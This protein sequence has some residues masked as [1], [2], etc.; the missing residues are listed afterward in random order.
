MHRLIQASA[1]NTHASVLRDAGYLR[2]G[3][4]ASSLSGF[5]PSPSVRSV[6]L[7]RLKPLPSLTVQYTRSENASRIQPA[8][9]YLPRP[10]VLC[11]HF[12]HVISLDVY[13]SDSFRHPFPISSFLNSNSIALLSIYFCPRTLLYGSGNPSTAAFA[14]HSFFLA[15]TPPSEA[16][17]P[18]L[19]V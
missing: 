8:A 9:E 13:D 18:G 19:V 2:D 3:T 6:L 11:T 1:Y 15:P 7:P 17:R 16:R 12:A 10:S 5:L 4:T 14:F